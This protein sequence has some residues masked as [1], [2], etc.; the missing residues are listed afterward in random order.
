MD[1]TDNTQVLNLISKENQLKTKLNL[2]KII[3]AEYISLNKSLDTPEKKQQINTLID[4]LLRLSQE[5]NLLSDEIKNSTWEIIDF[6]KNIEG[7]KM[8][9]DKNLI[10]IITMINEQEKELIK[11]KQEIDDFD[12][13]S[14]EFSKIYVSENIKYIFLFLITLILI[15]TIITSIAVPY[16]T[17]L[18]KMVLGLL[19]IVGTYHFYQLVINKLK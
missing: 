8:I 1:N 19:S 13:T 9:S 14:K 2:Y 7:H 5:I 18:E 6:N 16:K 12:G 4:N 11:T 15:Y 10:N 17:N 3:N